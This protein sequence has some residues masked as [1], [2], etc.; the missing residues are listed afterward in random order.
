MGF[1][2]VDESSA[3]LRGFSSVAR[4]QHRL[5]VALPSARDQTRAVWPADRRQFIYLQLFSHPTPP[6]KP[7]VRQRQPY[8]IWQGS[9][10]CR[11]TTACDR[12]CFKRKHCHRSRVLSLPPPNARGC[13]SSVLLVAS[14]LGSLSYVA[15][16]CRPSTVRPNISTRLRGQPWRR[17]CHEKRDPVPF[18]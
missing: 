5:A 4:P 11:S 2:D 9:C 13:G 1:L 15:Q 12:R 16:A 14:R 8:L 18:L 17:S 7:I 3:S 10:Y 6:V